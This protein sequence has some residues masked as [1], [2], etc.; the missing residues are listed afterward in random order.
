MT[1]LRLA[2]IG[3]G[4]HATN[5]LREMPFIPEIDLVAVCDVQPEL[6]RTT[7]RRFGALTSYTDFQKMLDVEHPD[8]VAVIGPP[9][10]GVH[11][12]AAVLDAGFHLYVEKPVGRNS[13][14]A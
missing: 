6:A 12:G 13:R 8:A 10:M 3:C 1:Q 5:L 4:R 11:I 9:T 7:A 14:E 2:F